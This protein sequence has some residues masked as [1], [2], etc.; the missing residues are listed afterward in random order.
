MVSL[1][2]AMPNTGRHSAIYLR[3]D[4]QK[5][6]A[7]ESYETSEDGILALPLQILTITDYDGNKPQIPFVDATSFRAARCEVTE[8]Q[9]KLI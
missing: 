8:K 7:V 9:G 3:Q 2:L 1:P 5:L 4:Y 6:Q